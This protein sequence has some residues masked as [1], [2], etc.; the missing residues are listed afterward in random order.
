MKPF[1]YDKDI[2]KRLTLK[3]YLFV[4]NYLCNGFNATR[5]VLASGYNVSSYDSA[6]A[7]GHKNLTNVYLKRALVREIK[8][9]GLTDERVCDLMYKAIESGLGVK[10]TNK[11][12]IE[13]IRLYFKITVDGNI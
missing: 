10:A 13:A 3:Q 9:A 2:G 5:A 11:D 4:K 6:K 7:I 8:N 12:S 1:I